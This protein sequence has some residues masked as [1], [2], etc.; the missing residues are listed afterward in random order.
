M[1]KRKCPNC[2][3]TM[4]DIN[5]Y[6]YK[7]G[8][9]MQKCKSCLTLHV[10]VFDPQ[11]FTWILKEADVPYLPSEW[12]SLR[13]KEYAKNPNKIKSSVVVGR[14]LSKMKLKQWKKYGYADTEKLQE[15]YNDFQK[16]ESA[17]AAQ[18]EEYIRK[19]YEQGQISQ[20]QYRTST[21]T[22]FQRKYDVAEAATQKQLIGEQNYY[23]QDN[24]VSEE[25]V[26]DLAED[27]TEDDKKYLLIKWGR[28]YTANDWVLLQKDYNQMIQSFDIQ[29]QDT[30]N[31][32]ILIC[33][34]NLKM[35]RALDE[36]DLD[37]YQKLA[38]VSDT[39]R[40]SAKFTAA[41]NKEQKA[42]VFDSIGQLVAY[43]ERYGHRIPKYQIKAPLDIVDKVIFDLKAYNKQLIY[44]DTS[45]ARQIE[46][47]LKKRSNLQMQKKNREDAEAAGMD[48]VDITDQDMHEES[49]RVQ[50]QRRRDE[51][52]TGG[53]NK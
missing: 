48:Y 28:M 47:Y 41:Q 4:Q 23:N 38:R 51:T 1:P 27:L 14:Y 15:Q 26:P 10:D 44:S 19:Q 16:E 30:R 11:T 33:K 13:D 24:F 17:A 39:L 36:G 42:S 32:L 8:T 29:D 6:S 50:E 49:I 53:K 20:A 34:T 45:L 25:D 2:G 31:T 35:N 22:Q 12:N 46:D 37:G 43:C 5:F 3:R 18:Q 40:K 7:D 52:I 9:K 21:S